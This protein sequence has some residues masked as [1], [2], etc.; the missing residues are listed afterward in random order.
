[1]NRVYIRGYV[2][3]AYIALINALIIALKFTLFL[4][5]CLN[6]INV[7]LHILLILR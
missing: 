4:S 2:L 3:N 7:N 6:V 1:M 5:F